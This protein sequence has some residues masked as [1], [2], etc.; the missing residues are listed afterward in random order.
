[1]LSGP[2]PAVQIEV[3]KFLCC[4]FRL[5]DFCCRKLKNISRKWSSFETKLVNNPIEPFPSRRQTRSL[6]NLSWAAGCWDFHFRCG[7]AKNYCC[8]CNATG[9]SWSCSCRVH[10]E[11]SV[12]CEASHDSSGEWLTVCWGKPRNLFSTKKIKEKKLFRSKGPDN[13]VFLSIA[14]WS[15]DSRSL[16][17]ALICACVWWFAW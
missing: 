17:I 10:G 13:Y 15:G 7:S 6:S 5:E 2:K 3:I 16:T 14:G 12:R 8:N 11:R 1:M 9:G 4:A